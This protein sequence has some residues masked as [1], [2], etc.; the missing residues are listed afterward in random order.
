MGGCGFATKHIIVLLFDSK[1]MSILTVKHAVYFFWPW[2]LNFL[3]VAVEIRALGCDHPFMFPSDYDD[4][5]HLL[6]F[7]AGGRVGG[8]GIWCI[9]PASGISQFF[10]LRIAKYTGEKRPSFELSSFRG[11]WHSLCA[12]MTRLHFWDRY[13]QH[14]YHNIQTQVAWCICA[15]E[16]LL[17]VVK[18]LTYICIIESGLVVFP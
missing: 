2:T 6:Y 7:G 14:R 4:P 5:S 17:W 13:S 15:S 18:K 8:W 1:M 9:W 3:A 16:Q 12:L 11:T 10:L